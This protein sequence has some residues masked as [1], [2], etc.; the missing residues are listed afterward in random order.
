MFFLQGRDTSDHSRSSRCDCPC[1]LSL[2]RS[3]DESWYVKRF[4]CQHTHQLSVS[5]GEKRRWP[6]HSRI[7][8]NTRELVRHL[9]ANNVQLSRVC[10]IVGTVHQS[11]S[12]VPFSRQS[13]HTLC[14]KLAQESI[15]GDM[16]KTLENF[17][18]I[19][20]RDPGLG[21]EIRL[22]NRRASFGLMFR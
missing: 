22:K 3:D 13:V 6:S 2:L 16:T 1:I 8:G 18:R 4:V 11:D 17:A 15:E 19:K 20:A 21:C 9:R 5:C 12:Y 7:D 10:S 14:A